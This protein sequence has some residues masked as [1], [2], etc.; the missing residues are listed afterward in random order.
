MFAKVQGLDKVTRSVFGAVALGAVALPLAGALATPEDPTQGMAAHTAHEA[1][2]APAG[3][4][5]EQ[6]A[7]SRTL[8]NQYGCTACHSLSA[9]GGSGQIGPSLDGNAALTQ[10][11]VVNIVSNGQGA[12]PSFGGMMDAEQIETLAAYIIEVKR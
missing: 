9:A 1:P 2:A 7:A 6:I 11:Y 8:F 4:S 10:D 3:L 12:M 5:A